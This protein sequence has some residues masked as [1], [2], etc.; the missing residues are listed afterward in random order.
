M[1]RND[2]EKVLLRKAGRTSGVVTQKMVSF[3]LDIDNMEWLDRQPN[4]GRYINDLIA[5][6]RD[7]NK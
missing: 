6:D 2:E 1:K 7:R 5:A 4:K 3:R